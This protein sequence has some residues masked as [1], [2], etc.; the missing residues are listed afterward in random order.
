MAVD[1]TL[2][3]SNGVPDMG[4]TMEE[5]NILNEEIEV[6]TVETPEG[7]TT[8]NVILPASVAAPAAVD[9]ED[10]EQIDI[11]GV[12]PVLQS[13]NTSRETVTA[14]DANGLKAAFLGL[15][16]DYETVITDYTYTSSNGY[17][18]HTIDVQPDY[19]WI[20]AAIMALALVWCCFKAVTISMRGNYRR[21][22]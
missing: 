8:I 3:M 10:G 17:T 5:N 14:N 15:V 13:V 21:K 9:S 16:G 7:N 1:V 19:A 12:T 6:Q 4:G 20:S 22:R 18:T 11:Q 2:N